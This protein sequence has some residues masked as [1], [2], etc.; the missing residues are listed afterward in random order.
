MTWVS[1]L[2]KHIS[3]NLVSDEE[4]KTVEQRFPNNPPQS[5]EEYYYRSIFILSYLSIFNKTCQRFVSFSSYL[6]KSNHCNFRAFCE[7]GT[8]NKYAF[9]GFATFTYLLTLLGHS[10]ALW[11]FLGHCL[12]TFWTF[13]GMFGR[14]WTLLDTFWHF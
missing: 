4:F 2:Q 3:D 12:D 8:K 6:Q 5:K 9:R 7:D 13:F 10:S 11:D 1:T 14:F